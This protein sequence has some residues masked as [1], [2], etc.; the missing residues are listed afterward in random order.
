MHTSSFFRL[1]PPPSFLLMNYVGL[2]IS[3]DAIRCLEYSRSRGGKTVL[4]RYS[5]TEIP[6]GLITGGDVKDEARLK[7][8]LVALDKKMN[9]TYVKVSIPEEKAY[10]F[11][12]QI[13]PG[14]IAEIR[15]NIEFK[16][17]EN[18]PLAA[19]DAVFYYDL[20]PLAV[21]GGVLRASVSVVP[22]TY[23]ERYTALLNSAGM[24]PVA[25]EIVP[26]AIARAIMPTH[27]EETVLV[28][29]L[30][31]KKTG[32]YIV[33]GGVVSF[34]STVN[35]GSKTGGEDYKTTLAK[36]IDRAY[37]YWATREGVG[38]ITQI[39]LVGKDAVTYENSLDG[40]VSGVTVPVRVANAWHNT[41]DLDHYVP[42]ISRSDSLEYVVAA[43]L[44]MD[45]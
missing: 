45:N 12:T 16:L 1:F 19:P 14:S 44:A 23:I 13:N 17:E 39:V 4:G 37:S 11:Q 2:D 9:L 31:N 29:H 18:V 32:I 27:S 28:V 21:T 10:L 3:D 40:A 36:E 6:E 22:R 34:T 33:S 30:M 5:V 41:L 8:L 38:V 25:F 35:S 7:E 42:P 20:L 24:F 43:G 26:K 15:Q